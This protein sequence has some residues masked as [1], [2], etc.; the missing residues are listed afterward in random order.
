MK[1]QLS[2]GRVVI[3]SSIVLADYRPSVAR[4]VPAPANVTATGP[5]TINESELRLYSTDN[6]FTLFYGKEADEMLAAL[7]K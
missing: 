1:V 7:M 6:I 4:Q 2:T 5:V 3:L